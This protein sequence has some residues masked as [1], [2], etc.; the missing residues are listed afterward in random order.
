MTEY[1][2]AQINVG[3]L[4]HPL[5]APETLEFVENLDPVNALAEAS[6]GFVWRLTD[7]DGSS[8]SYVSVAGMDHPLDVVNYSVWQDFEALKSFVFKTDHVGFLRRRIEWFERPT[9]AI[10]ACWWVPAGSIS[11]AE[12]LVDEA[13]ARLEHLREHGSSQTA[14][15]INK[16]MPAPT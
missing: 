5:D 8:S 4:R 6:P 1:H 11:D 10:A 2:L 14:W 16:P 3:R 13:Y 15:A 12:P 9:Q 7:A